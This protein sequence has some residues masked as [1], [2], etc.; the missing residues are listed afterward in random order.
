M[1]D[2][3]LSNVVLIDPPHFELPEAPSSVAGSLR[4]MLERLRVLKASSFA[5]RAMAT[6]S[7]R[8]ARTL[9]L[10]SRKP[11]D[12][13]PFAAE[14]GAD[15]AGLRRYRGAEMRVVSGADRTSDIAGFVTAGR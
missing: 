2:G 6:L 13:Q 12:S 11:E 4:R 14:F 8:G 1:A 7:R 15:G 3:R 9:Y 10:F 5:H